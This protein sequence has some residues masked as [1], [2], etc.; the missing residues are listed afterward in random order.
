MSSAIIPVSIFVSIA[1]VIISYFYWN[2]KN[3]NALMNV[4]Q[5]S[6]ES[7]NTITPELLTKLSAPMSPK[8]RDFRRGVVIFMIG[9]AGMLSAFFIDDAE[10]VSAFR[11]LSM[12]PLLVGAGFLIVW[13]VSPAQE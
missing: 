12:F 9:V 5:R 7:G 6:I 11:A 1:A 3:R 13:K 10:L 8:L 2:H 4:V